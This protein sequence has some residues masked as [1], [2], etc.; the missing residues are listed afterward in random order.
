MNRRRNIRYLIPEW[1]INKLH[2]TS[3]RTTYSIDDRQNMINFISIP[4][5]SCCYF[6]FQSFKQQQQQKTI[7]VNALA[8]ASSLL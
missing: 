4:V 6:A 3:D 7:A 1:S 2:H 8:Y 5:Y